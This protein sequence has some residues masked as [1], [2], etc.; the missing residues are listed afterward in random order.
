MILLLRKTQKHPYYSQGASKNYG[1]RSYLDFLKL[2][3]TRL[4]RRK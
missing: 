2:Q 1:E 4:N 3:L